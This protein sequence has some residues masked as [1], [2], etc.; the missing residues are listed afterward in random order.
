MNDIFWL[1]RT[2]QPIAP[3]GVALSEYPVFQRSI[4]EFSRPQKILDLSQG[5]GYD[6][7]GYCKVQVHC[8]IWLCCDMSQ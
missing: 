8:Y 7:D 2:K 3:G 5:Q 6:L 1:L 4:T